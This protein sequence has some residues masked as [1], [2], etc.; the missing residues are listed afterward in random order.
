[1]A[2][3]KGTITMFALTIVDTTNQAHVEILNNVCE[4][5]NMIKLKSKALWEIDDKETV[6]K[7]Q[8]QCADFGLP[9]SE[10]IIWDRKAEPFEEKEVG[11]VQVGSIVRQNGISFKVDYHFT[12]DVS[13]INLEDESIIEV[14]KKSLVELIQY[15]N[16]EEIS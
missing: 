5:F 14:D 16:I 15:S 6:L 10:T 9:L 12:N 7:A 3:K 2:K 4:A 8:G 1:M 13:L 11:T